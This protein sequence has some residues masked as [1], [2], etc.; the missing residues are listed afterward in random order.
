GVRLWVWPV[1]GPPLPVYDKP[2]S[3]VTGPIR[4]RNEKVRATL[5]RYQRGEVK[6][7]PGFICLSCS[8]RDVCREGRVG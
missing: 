1:L 8:V 6:P 5:E 7:N 3:Q 4:W 2:I